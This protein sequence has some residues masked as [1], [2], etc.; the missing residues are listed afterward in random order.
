MRFSRLRNSFKEAFLGE[1]VR[2]QGTG[3]IRGRGRESFGIL[4][5]QPGCCKC[6]DCAK[7]R[8]GST[9]FHTQSCRLAR[10]ES[11]QRLRKLS[12]RSGKRVKGKYFDSSDAGS[13]KREFRSLARSLSAVPGKSHRA[14]LASAP[15]PIRVR[16]ETLHNTLARSA[17]TMMISRPVFARCPQSL[18]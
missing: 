2:K 17:S 13:G 6:A 7:I 9:Q 16:L 3:S 5:S 1:D 12:T 15:P 8:C 10:R 18:H 4:S 11:A 14:A